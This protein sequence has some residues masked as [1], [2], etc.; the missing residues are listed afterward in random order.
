MYVT[1]VYVYVHVQVQRTGLVHV[2]IHTHIQEQSVLYL[3]CERAYESTI[4]PPP[5]PPFQFQGNG[6]TII[7]QKMSGTRPS[8]AGKEEAVEEAEEEVAEVEEEEERG[9]GEMVHIRG[10]AKGID[11]IHYTIVE[12]FL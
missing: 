1:A 9:G 3:L 2:Y 10:C 7:P 12:I 8:R 4:S 11:S 6:W 5:P